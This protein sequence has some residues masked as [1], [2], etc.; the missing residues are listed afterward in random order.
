MSG[1]TSVLIELVLPSISTLQLYT[2]AAG[3]VGTESAI[4]K[5]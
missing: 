5:V 1:L 4:D 3:C 2:S